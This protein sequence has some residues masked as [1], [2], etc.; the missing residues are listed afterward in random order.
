MRK[1]GEGR[2]E[3]REERREK[4]EERRGKREERREKRGDRKERGEGT[5]GS[6]AVPRAPRGGPKSYEKLW[7]KLL[8]PINFYF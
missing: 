8:F 1:E 7:E 5:E 4:R 6:W 2:G 3:K